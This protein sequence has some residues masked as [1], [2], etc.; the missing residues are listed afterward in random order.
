M[1]GPARLLYGLRLDVNRAPARSLEALPGIGPHLAEA[2]VAARPFGSL[3]DVRRVPGM[4]P[5]RLARVA[6]Y[7]EVG[8]EGLSEPGIG[9][10]PGGNGEVPEGRR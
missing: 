3:A 4:G 8:Q 10:L 9:S 5:S 7:L 1:R 2:I 6:P